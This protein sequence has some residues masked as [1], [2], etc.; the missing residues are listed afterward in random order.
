[1]FAT[2]PFNQRF[3]PVNVFF[4]S[5][6]WLAA[7]FS[8]HDLTDESFVCHQTVTRRIGASCAGAPQ[9]RQPHQRARTSG[10]SASTALR[11]MGNFLDTPI[12]EKETEVGE[13]L[14]MSYGLSAMQGWRAQ[15]EDDHLQAFGLPDVRARPPSTHDALHLRSPRSQRRMCHDVPRHSHGAFFLTSAGA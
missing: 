4:C 10:S 14:G 8:K 9:P 7:R 5:N 1:M 2:L 11:G 3:S 13:G 15:M 6:F 12:T